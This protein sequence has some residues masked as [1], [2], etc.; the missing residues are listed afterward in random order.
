MYFLVYYFDIYIFYFKFISKV[1]VF[2][3]FVELLM[4][5]LKGNDYIYVKGLFLIYV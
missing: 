2:L 3:F 1:W 4:K 5:C